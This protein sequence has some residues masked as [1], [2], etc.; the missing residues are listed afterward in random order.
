MLAILNATGETEKLRPLTDMMPSPMVPVVDRPIM[1]YVI[2][3]LARQGIK[4]IIVSLHHLANQIEAYFGNGQRW[5]VS[6]EYVLQKEPW[7]SAGALK[8]ADYMLEETCLVMP[9]DALIDVDVNA[10]LAQHR[11]RKS[12]VTIVVH[13]RQYEQARILSRGLLSALTR[14]PRIGQPQSH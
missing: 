6:I 9:A 1:E 12:S 4:K 13:P 14:H 10:V 2:E 3:L 11:E 8:W 7:G 5:G